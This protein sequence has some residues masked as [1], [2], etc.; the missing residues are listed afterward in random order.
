MD[1]ACVGTTFYE[2]DA[3]DTPAGRFL[4]YEVLSQGSYRLID[5]VELPM[6]VWDIKPYLDTVVFSSGAAVSIGWSRR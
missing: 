4:M 5:A 6:P 3:L 2:K 1:V